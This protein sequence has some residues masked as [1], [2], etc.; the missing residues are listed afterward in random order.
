M[1]TDT[2]TDPKG[3]IHDSYRINGITPQECRSIFLDWALSLPAGTDTA[4]ALRL[5]LDRHG[6]SAPEHPMT[7]VLREGL[8]TPANP[9]RRGGWRNRPRGE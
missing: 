3:L 7:H 8:E 1:K 4:H 5:L 9:R 2:E 6:A